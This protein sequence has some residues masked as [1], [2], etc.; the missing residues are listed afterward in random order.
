ME[1][2]ESFSRK[3]PTHQFFT[4]KL[5]IFTKKWNK[6]WHTWTLL[7]TIIPGIVP[8]QSIVGKF[9]DEYA[10]KIPSCF[11]GAGANSYFVEVEEN[12]TKKAKCVRKEAI[13]MFLD[14]THYEQIVMEEIDH[15]L[16]KMCVFR[17]Y[18]HTTY[19]GKLNKIALSPK[20]N[21]RSE[22]E[23]FRTGIPGAIEYVN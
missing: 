21:K 19:T 14:K 6:T 10:G 9:K 16:C 13:K 2:I 7:I 22:I 17:S 1:I 12:N 8:N 20:D 4:S 23:S 11:L 18:S 5:W 15:V 3:I